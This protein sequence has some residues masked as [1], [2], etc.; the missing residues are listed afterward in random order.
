MDNPS[1]DKIRNVVLVG[2]G[3][4]GKTSLVEALLSRAGVIARMGRVEDGTTVCD[5][6]P[7]EVKRSM[8][9]SL[10]L[11]P[12]DWRAPDGSTYKINLIDT[13]GY[14]DFAADVDAALSIADLAVVV[15][16][17]VDGVEVGTEIAWAKC[18]AAGLPRLVF[19]NKEDKPRADFHRVL[20][21]L[22]SSFG[23]G[24]APLELPLGEEEK[25]HG[26]A[27]VLTDQ[28]FEYETDGHH[29][30]EA[31]P[32][33]VALRPDEIVDLVVGRL[34]KESDV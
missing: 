30:T 5:T 15:V 23:H 16:S 18:A 19:V 32:A 9:L 17:A 29:H 10:A 26:V 20:T 21:S 22:R 12:F 6:E 4:S 25:F 33:D 27:D 2:H 24:F 8:S 31:I 3:G 1:S 34:K 7:E 14:L 28:G 11:A 13:P